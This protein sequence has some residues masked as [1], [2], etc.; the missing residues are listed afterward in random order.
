MKIVKWLTLS[1][2]IGHWGWSGQ[3]HQARAYP[4]VA[5]F[6]I[7]SLLCMYPAKRSEYKVRLNPFMKCVRTR[8]GLLRIYRLWCS[9]FSMTI[10]LGLCKGLKTAEIL[11]NVS[12]AQVWLGWQIRDHLDKSIGAILRLVSLGQWQEQDHHC[13]YHYQHVLSH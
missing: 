10:K 7:R 2:K 3:G 12:R 13:H 1:G 11:P 5:H 6:I 4:T 8:P 9:P